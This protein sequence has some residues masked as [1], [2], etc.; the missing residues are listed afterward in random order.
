MSIRQKW[1][2]R[3]N[4]GK[5]ANSHE[6]QIELHE[7]SLRFDLKNPSSSQE[8]MPE[9][10]RYDKIHSPTPIKPSSDHVLLTYEKREGQRLFIDHPDFAKR[11]LDFAPNITAGKHTWHLLKW[12]LGMAGAMVLFWALTFFNIISP[13][14]YIA[15]LLPDNT[16]VSLG[17][18]VVK[19]VQR[20]NKVCN[21]PEGSKAFNKLITR[22]NQGL[23]KKQNFD[24]KIVDLSYENAFAAPGD[25]II[26]SGKLIRNANSA[27][28]VAGVLA[29][30]MGH[31]VKLHPE[32]NIVRALG[33]LAA[34]QLFTAGESGTF[35]ELAFFLVQSGYSRQAETEADQFAAKVLNH[36]NIDTRP[37]AGFFERIIKQRKVKLDEGK[38]NS[39]KK[40]KEKNSKPVK[41]DTTDTADG[42]S[43]M[44]WISS[45]PA[46]NKRIEFF[47]KSK[48]ST[49]PEILSETEW[50][51]LQ[52]ICGPKK[53]K[54]KDKAPKKE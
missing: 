8:T 5:T 22:L 4:D 23:D 40:E 15:N 37:L 2:G 3:W 46:T 14:K 6:V 17:K 47:N 36:S 50:Q 29:H 32:T 39:Q 53:E 26:M 28:E 52:K 49:T 44:E 12:P 18:G 45:H 35:G 13:A 48:I 1:N 42:R 20:K 24:I 31:A 30:E 16:R 41:V 54:Q 11:I 38:K 27:D 25:Q 10:W 19:T 51:A 43:L 21:T 34:L 9:F 33:I 7:D